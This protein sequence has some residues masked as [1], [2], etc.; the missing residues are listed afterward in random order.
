[1]RYALGIDGGGSNCDA[2]LVD[3]TAS[4][5]GRGRGGSTVELYD[6]PSV[7]Q[8]SY[9]RAISEALAPVRAAEFWV[10]GH[11]P[12]GGPWQQLSRFGT[13]V[14][15]RT[16]GETEVAFA[17]V[18]K[19]W[20]VI[21]LSGTG[22]FVHALTPDGRALHWGGLGPMLGD[23][24]SAYEI[25]LSALRAAFASNWSVSYRTSLA[26]VVPRALGA[27]DLDEVFRLVYGEN[28][29]RR[30]IASVAEAV[31]REAAAG[32]R[33]S[34]N[35]LR[36]AA[37]ELAELAVGI[38]RELDL[39][40][41]AFPV[42]ASGGVAQKSR[43]WWTQICSRI[44]AVAPHAHPLVPRLPPAAG[45]ALLALRDMGINWTPGLIDRLVTSIR[46]F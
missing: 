24:G 41:L 45:A 44:T 25:G 7:V 40:E 18:Q 42:I 39:G 27:A 9:V 14:H 16:V 10:A 34:E 4:V 20:G 19:E 22:S 15:H 13:V 33:V 38:I 2:I 32:D 30:M 46:A 3:Q 37:D 35:C 28:L 43:I 29:G 1:M 26:E 8:A 31:D 36:K 17:T 23:Y 21:V 6:P 5:V 12:Q 11:L